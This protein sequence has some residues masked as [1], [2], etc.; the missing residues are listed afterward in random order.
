MILYKII[1]YQ[2]TLNQKMAIDLLSEFMQQ[3]AGVLV[4]VVTADAKLFMQMQYNVNL[5]VLK[6][7]LDAADILIKSLRQFA[8]QRNDQLKW[9]WNSAKACTCFAKANQIVFPMTVD[10]LQ[11]KKKR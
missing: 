7:K 10:E 9:A 6:G 1:S 11:S 5:G 3:Y 2:A 8:Y 4:E